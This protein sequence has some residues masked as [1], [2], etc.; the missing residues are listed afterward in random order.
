[1]PQASNIVI[2]DAQ[3]TPVNHTYVPIGKDANGVFWFEDQSA[4]NAVGNW[5]ISVLQKRPPAA[6]PGQM[7]GNRFYRTLIT[8]HQPT[9]ETVSNSTISG[10][11]PAPVIAYNNRFHG[12]YVSAER[13]SLQNR[14]DISKMAPLLLQNTQI[15]AV[16]EDQQYLW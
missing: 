3:A 16:F 14:K 7:T 9:L 13:S 11:A 15:R 5:K 10:I 8:M 1:M 2:A 6:Q 4:A 12:E